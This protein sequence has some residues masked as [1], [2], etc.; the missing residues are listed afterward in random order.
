LSH[1]ER[2]KNEGYFLIQ[3]NEQLAWQWTD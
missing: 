1:I 3:M 2:N